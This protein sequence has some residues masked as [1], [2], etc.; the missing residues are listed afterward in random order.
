LG[1]HLYH[2]TNNELPPA[3]SERND[4]IGNPPDQ[5]TN[6]QWTVGWSWLMLIAPYIEQRGAYEAIDWVERV[7]SGPNNEVN[8]VKELK[9]TGL[10]CPTR[11]SSAA[12]TVGTGQN[13]YSNAQGNPTTNAMLGG[14][15]TDYAACWAGYWPWSGCLIQPAM[16]RIQVPDPNVPAV[17]R[18]IS[19]LKSQTTLGS[20]TDGTANTIALG[21]KNMHPDWLNNMDIERPAAVGHSLHPYYQVRLLG[22]VDPR[23][24]IDTN[25]PNAN[26]ST[27]AHGLPNRLPIPRTG[28][29]QYRDQSGTARTVET[30]VW[31]FGSWHPHVSLF[32]FAD[33]TVHPIRNNLDPFMIMPYL[34][35][36]NDGIVA[37]WTE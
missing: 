9:G 4:I 13:D 26:G 32:T 25:G 8:A 35:S 23:G 21:E 10:L 24:V 36:R 16:P 30:W 6:G 12:V 19:R 18:I 2:D 5:Q 31:T 15:P 11:R 34:G 14:Q 3:A 29:Y 7:P 1:L 37:N 27:Y 33:A 20:I 22:Y 17:P 28:T